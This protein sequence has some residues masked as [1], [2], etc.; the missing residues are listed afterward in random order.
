[1]NSNFTFPPQKLDDQAITA[2]FEQPLEINDEIF[3]DQS[4]IT[5]DSSNNNTPINN[6]DSLPNRPQTIQ[7]NESPT[8]Q[9]SNIQH[10][11]PVSSSIPQIDI[12]SPNNTP[13]DMIR[14]QNNVNIYSTNNNT[15]P[16]NSVP[17]P[18]YVT[19]E[20]SPK[21]NAP[22]PFQ[23]P[24]PISLSESI[25][26]P[27]TEDP[28][29]QNSNNNINNPI[30]INS[31]IEVPQSLNIPQSP[32]FQQEINNPQ[33]IETETIIEQ[34]PNQYE[35]MVHQEQDQHIEVPSRTI[36]TP[37][38]ATPPPAA[39]PTTV[40]YANSLRNQ[41]A[42]DMKAP[43]EYA[44]HILFTKFV[45]NAENK[46]NLCLQYPLTTEP[47]IVDILGEGVDPFF[48]KIIESLG[49][50]AKKKPK[51][52]IDAMMFWRKTK[53]EIVSVAAEDVEKLLKE[54]D[55]EMEHLN[56]ANA[57]HSQQNSTLHTRTRRSY[58]HTKTSSVESKFTHRRRNS[59]KSSVTTKNI[60]PSSQL[61]DLEIQLEVAKENAFQADRKSL[62]SIYILC[63]VLIEIIKQAPTDA[64]QDLS[65]K[66]EEIIFTQLKTTDPLSISSSIIKSSNWNAFAEL[67]GYMSDVKFISVSDRFIAELEKVP[68][69]LT[70]DEEASIHLLILGMR[71]IRLKHY[72]LD[73]FEETADFMK[74]LA[75]FFSNT[76]NEVIQVA[77]AEVIS[78]LLLPLA[79][80]LTAEV[81]HPTWVDAISL[82]LGISQKLQLR[83]ET[84]VSGFKLNVAVLSVAPHE[85]FSKYWFQLIEGNIDQIRTRSLDDRVIFAVGLS[86]LIWVYLYRCPDTLNNTTRTLLK[87]YEL[88]ITDSK[89]IG[90]I[91]TDMELISPLSDVLVSIGYSYPNLLMENVL[92]P[93]IKNSFD[94]K[95][96]NNI[97]Y[98]KL[99]LAI[100]TYRGLLMTTIRP[101]F[102]EEDSRYYDKGLDDLNI[103]QKEADVLNH[104][105]ICI[106]LHK[107]FILLDSNIGSEVWSPENEH[108]KQS[109]T[110]LGPFSFKFSG[111]NSTHSFN[112]TNNNN[113]PDNELNILLFS[114]L[115]ET[116]PCCITIY[117]K[118][119]FKSTIE[120]FSRN[121]VHSNYF[122][123]TSCQL[124]LKS[125]ASRKNP[126]TL[127]TWFAKYSFDFDEKTQSSYDMTYLNS[128][129]YK[130]LLVLYVELLDC[131][132]Q[133]FQNSNLREQKRDTGLDGIDL[134]LKETDMTE[135]KEQDSLEWKSTITVIEDVEGNGLF[136]LC[137]QDA[138]V[139]RLAIEIL[140]ITRKF[141]FAMFEKTIR[142]TDTHAR[143]PS[144]LTT[145]R[146]TR[147]IDVLNDSDYSSL[148]DANR[149]PLSTVEKKRLNKLNLK[150]KKGLLIRLAESD[151]GVD[152]ALWQ[153]IFPKLL[154]KIVNVSPM[155]M[156]LCRS[157]VCIRLVQVHDIILR[158][159]NGIEH[160]PHELLPETIANQWKLYLI[161][162]CTSLTS[163][164]DQKLHIPDDIK[165]H[166]RKKSQQI[167]T[168]QHQKI[169]SATSIFKVVLPLLNAKSTLI[170]DAVIVGLSSM[171]INIYKAYIENVD[172]F[173][174]GWKAN[175]S[176]N[177]MRV[178]MFHVLT[179]LSRFLNDKLILDDIWI[180][181]KVSEFI[182]HT[183]QFLQDEV[184]Q[185]TYEFQSLRSYFAEFVL[186]YYSTIRDHPSVNE[187][188]PFQ[189][190]TSCF[191]YFKEWCGYGPYAY[192]GEGRY[193]SMI[194]NAQ[195]NRVQTTI[196]AGIEFQRN[197]LE[198]LA[199]ETILTLCSDSITET[200]NGDTD[201]PI[202]VSFDTT[203]LL[204]L[205]EAL[206][207]AD[208]Q[209]IKNLGVRTLQNLLEKNT[210]NTK[211]FKDVFT[212]C[213]SVHTNASVS[214]FYYT[215]LCKAI[216]KTDTLILDEDELVSLGLYGLMSDD[217]SM[218]ICA[219]E[220]LSV[221]ETKLH[222]SS[223]SK[224]FRERAANS[225]KTVY[226]ATAKEISSIFADLSSHDLCLRTFANL[227]NL[228]NLL[229][230]QIKRDVL[231]LL[232]PWVNKLVLKTL[233]DSD[234]IMVLRNIFYITIELNEELPMEVEQ[235][236]ISL[237]KGNSFQN[238][239]IA[240]EYIIVSSINHR[241]P[242][243]VEYCRDVVLYLFNVPGNLGLI[244][245]LLAN[246]EPKLMIPPSN[247]TIIEYR[248]EGKYSFVANI[249]DRLN[250]KERGVIFS[251]AQLSLIFLVNILST[252]HETTKS[253]LPTLLHTSICLLDHYV[254]QIQQS[255]SKIICD[256]IFTFA[257][258]HEKSEETV[259][260]LGSKSALWS[261]DNLNKD[262]AGSRSP[263]TMDSLIRNL[264]L[265][266]SETEMLR[267]DWQRVA[268]K[269]A[270]TCSVRHI[271]CRSFQIFRSLLDFL[272]Q[273]MLRD[274][275]HRLSNTV[276]D[277]NIDIQGFAMQI[278]MTLNAITAELDPADLIN[279]P[280]LLWSITAC[281]GSIHE[282]EF[283][284]VL[285]CFMKF[286]SKID[287]DSPDTVQCLVATFP[288]NWEGR[289]EGLQQIVMSGLRSSNSLDITWKFLD[290]LNLLKDSRIIAE[291]ESRLLFALIANLP[292]FLYAMNTKEYDNIQQ[293]ASAL[294]SLANSQN[295]PSLSRLIDSL[296][297]NKFRSKKDFM[298]QIV[299]F[300]SRIYFPKYSFQTLIF[301]LGLLLNK[302]G[303][304]KEQSMVILKY[305]IPL[306]DLSKPEFVGVGAD[307]I[308]PLLRLLLTEYESQALEVLDCF[309]DV[310]GSK[311]DKDVLRLSMGNKDVKNGNTAAATLFGIPEESGWSI[312]MPKM[313]AA[314]TRHNVHAVFT[315]CTI[316]TGTEEDME[317]DTNNMEDVVEFHADSDYGPINNEN[318][319]TASINEEN[320]A[321]LSHMWAELDNLDSFFTKNTSNQPI[322][323]EPSD[324]DI[325]EGE[326]DPTHSLG[327]SATDN[328]Y[329][330]DFAPQ[331]YDKKVSDLLNR[332]LTKTNSNVSFRANLADSFIYNPSISNKMGYMR[333]STGNTATKF[334]GGGNRSKRSSRFQISPKNPTHLE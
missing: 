181:K 198:I 192:I 1:M 215:T 236:W 75:K 119:P 226:K 312:P 132:L 59:S 238:A 10:Y 68:Q 242:I 194:K 249:W 221:V 315:T 108:R 45:R 141:D 128:V 13:P 269:W 78:H 316:E 142:V 169:T 258:T 197:K 140:R 18:S 66:L 83:P 274:M 259:Q 53:S 299:S 279:F 195:N 241:N 219:V 295:Q 263:K 191:N 325:F 93:L 22:H 2:S 39:T 35:N 152:T 283:I 157:I 92:H 278:L 115:T 9:H 323:P 55:S 20:A 3:V 163:T 175:S 26:F 129:E 137:S 297:K 113:N 213:G 276:S 58:T 183:K 275:L 230:F 80:S 267:I 190:R 289:F 8:N 329:V 234:S 332:S 64:D 150:I 319:D 130:K 167:F 180:L 257:P 271:A 235:L 102:P 202:I 328:A 87:L 255:A 134:P 189:A 200:F 69:Q 188:F 111:D 170:K 49:H 185:I 61:K 33:Y 291:T 63:R 208:N 56:S 103:I 324:R 168:V 112:T 30:T 151:Y 99:L 79:G 179:I 184:I 60:S 149:A 52:V 288:S 57:T 51:P 293:A 118:L 304:V 220:L 36:I 164:A 327:T 268:L 107:L 174:C 261:Y 158:V 212:R 46:L 207:N 280:Q 303:W 333:H 84:W 330:G 98:E 300:I 322:V 47:P 246:L 292:R 106:Q 256:L 233:D 114:T 154:A 145:D 131:W 143:M 186:R 296:A 165:S 199:L 248:D 120:I 223:Y 273:S 187:L 193:S 254:P 244:D 123:S 281:L 6:T 73:K 232:V 67:L 101:D 298:S 204:S 96:L 135:H 146:G 117:K 32:H 29:F 222:N 228:L 24:L 311:T 160:D 48:D 314:T 239:H 125:L 23:F 34:S 250:Y 161:V 43:S 331:F 155:V 209:V 210:E 100:T 138:T 156:A 136:F 38:N 284:E 7:M 147:L 243:F 133:N 334:Y 247:K 12:P 44:L 260:L 127:I 104:E 122:I 110:Q 162:A 4:T 94:S 109:S 76:T 309:S 318:N 196:T 91:T 65:N 95:T 266:F 216:F 86:R 240:L 21:L 25:E 41:M 272:E 182:R 287:L 277:E 90:W 306:I 176:Q 116:I 139:R 19:T 172:K 265:I 121:A 105:E 211:L 62:I 144:Y 171:N 201:A 245:T 317:K 285:S 313:M 85:L 16:A 308:S 282:Q 97:V 253:N 5:N 225:S 224:V 290:K 54:Y 218:R 166:G 310:S 217:E 205:I 264:L 70:Q 270:T 153:R 231:T 326:P 82:L 227:T 294:I 307:L 148:L 286:I 302:V 11:T 40:D 42:T 203:S 15:I 237:G 31:S 321:S 206:F 214:I 81:N 301:F 27:Q 124:A 28:N 251:K 229:S 74:S 17:S 37:V 305:I 126:Y 77:Y 320:E 159:A 177:K 88:Y 14:Y 178:E 72:P 71:Y 173:L 89:K 252:P 50:I 262:K